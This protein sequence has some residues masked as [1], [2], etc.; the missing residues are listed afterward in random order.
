MSRIVDTKT[1]VCQNSSSTNTQ[2]YLN[3]LIGCVLEDELKNKLLCT[4]EENLQATA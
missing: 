4:T 2:D 1:T 3:I